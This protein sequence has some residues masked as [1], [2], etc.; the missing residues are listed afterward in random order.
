MKLYARTVGWVGL[1]L[2][3]DALADKCG[4]VPVKWTKE[5]K[6]QWDK[7]VEEN[8]GTKNGCIFAHPTLKQETGLTDA[9]LRSLLGAGRRQELN[10]AAHS[11]QV[12][13]LAAAL[14]DLLQ[15]NPGLQV[16]G[17][18]EPGRSQGT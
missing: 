2:L 10:T 1:R 11:M 9:L 12:K 18:N 7:R 14:Q 6:E 5:D 3:L 15:K 16:G 8:G 17:G 13:T 4:H